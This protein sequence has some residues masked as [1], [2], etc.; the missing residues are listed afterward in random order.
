MHKNTSVIDEPVVSDLPHL[1]DIPELASIADVTVPEPLKDAVPEAD[2]EHRDFP[3]H[4]FWR[5]IPAFKDIDY[6]QFMSHKF[7]LI[8]TV[9]GVDK[10]KEIVGDLATPEFLADMEAGLR[11]APMNVRVSPYLISRINWKHPYDDP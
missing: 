8:H 5:D 1:T 7:Q 4:E 10:L 9:T 2:L 11:A 3:D 6:E